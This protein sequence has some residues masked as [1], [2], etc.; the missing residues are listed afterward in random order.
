M[1]GTLQI[2]LSNAFYLIEIVAF[3]IQLN[4]FVRV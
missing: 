4:I 1:D 2:E 3:E